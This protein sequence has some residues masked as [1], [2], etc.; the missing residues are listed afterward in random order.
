MYVANFDSD[1]VSVI[2]P[3]KNTVIKNITVGESPSFIVHHHLE[4]LYT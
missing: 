4:I 1:T 2:N 3:T